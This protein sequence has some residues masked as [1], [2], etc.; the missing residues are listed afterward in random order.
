[1]NE[2]SCYFHINNELARA[3]LSAPLSQRF[4]DH[5]SNLNSTIQQL[6]VVCV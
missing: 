6:H 5:L 4:I 1:M 3:L 2:I